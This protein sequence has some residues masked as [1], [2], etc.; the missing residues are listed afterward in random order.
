MTYRRSPLIEERLANNR[1]RILLATRKLVSE[2]G[3]RDAQIAA[4]AAALI[5]WAAWLNAQAAARAFAAAE[6]SA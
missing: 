4:V 1:D 2:G 5:A 3:F 6:L